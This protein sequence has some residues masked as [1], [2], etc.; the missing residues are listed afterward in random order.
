[1]SWPT[2][3]SGFNEAGAASP[4]RSGVCDRE[5]GRGR[6]ASMRPGQLRPGDATSWKLPM[7]WK[8]SFNEAGAASPRRYPPLEETPYR[9]YRCF[10]EAGAASPRRWHRPVNDHSKES[11]FNEAGAAS[12]RRSA[13][14]ITTE[15]TRTRFNEAG[16]ASPRR[17]EPLLDVLSELCAASMRPGQ[18][19]PGD[20]WP[21]LS[22]TIRVPWLQ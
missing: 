13:T 19:R 1:M 5:L 9:T 6:L 21:R 22:F 16:A 4:R 7:L 8:R 10:N 20:T 3:W 18:L 14:W 17:S 2:C 11:S 12:P 15:T